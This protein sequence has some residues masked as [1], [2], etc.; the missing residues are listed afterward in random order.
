MFHHHCLHIDGMKQALKCCRCKK[1]GRLNDIHG[2]SLVEECP[3]FLALEQAIEPSINSFVT[4][5]ETPS[6]LDD[7]S[8]NRRRKKK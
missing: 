6:I 8:S 3:S 5:L 4:K 2:N 1:Y 7:I